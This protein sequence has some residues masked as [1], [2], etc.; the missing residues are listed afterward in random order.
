AL[1][2]VADEA[3]S[4]GELTEKRFNA[5]YWRLHPDI[6]GYRREDRRLQVTWFPGFR[7]TRGVAPQTS[8]K[9]TEAM[10]RGPADHG[11]STRVYRAEDEVAVVEALIAEIRREAAELERAVGSEAKPTAEPASASKPKQQKRSR[12]RPPEQAA[13]ETTM[14]TK[15]A[16]AKTH[17]PPAEP[18]RSKPATVD[19][20]K[21]RALA[22]SMEAKATAELG[23]DRL[24]NTPRRA[25]MAASIRDRARRQLVLAKTLRRIADAGEAGGY[26]YVSR[27][28]NKADL[29]ALETALSGA[30][31]E[32]RKADGVREY[33]KRADPQPVD[34][35]HA[36]HEGLRT[37][38]D[39]LVAVLEFTKG[40]QGLAGPRRVLEKA[41]ERLR[42]WGPLQP[43]EIEAL[44]ELIAVVRKTKAKD[45]PRPIEAMIES[46]RD[47]DRLTQLGVVDT[48]SLRAALREYMT[49]C[50][51][52]QR[53]PKDDPIAVKKRE[54]AFAKIPGF[55]PTPR[56]LVERMVDAAELAPG[57]RV[58]EPSAG[59]GAIALVIRE[60]HPDVEL[61]VIERQVSLRELLELQGF[62]PVADDFCAYT[63]AAPYDRILMNPPFETKQDIQH[64]GHALDLLAPGGRLVAIASAGLS[65]RD[66]PKTKALRDRVEALGGRIESLPQGSFEASGTGVSTVLVVVDQPPAATRREPPRSEPMSDCSVESTSAC[67]PKPKAKAK[68]KAKT[69]AE[70]KTPPG[71]KAKLAAAVAKQNEGATLATKPAPPKKRISKKTSQTAKAPTEAKTSKKAGK[72]KAGKKQTAKL[73]NWRYTTFR[74]DRYRFREVAGTFVVEREKDGKWSAAAATAARA[75]HEKSQSVCALAAQ[76][77]PTCG[78]AK[79]PKA[80]RVKPTDAQKQA[81]RK[82]LGL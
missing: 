48:D 37:E 73:P 22:D 6:H 40:A 28:A 72:K 8:D 26:Q 5:A 38:R 10:V 51:G 1:L 74:N 30:G 31:F 77:L 70:P 79:K 52:D 64:I 27:V 39:G 66:D 81:M 19:A 3:R 29:E 7:R 50:R 54:L 78:D 71:A 34:I 80:S 20:A 17:T 58:L 44:R 65:F 69:S 36:H 56:P 68:T 15:R 9:P 35:D 76:I 46:L 18:P 61:D 49:C 33:W 63:P 32:R 25:N 62:P 43:E 14:T 57:M 41:A 67:R 21:L 82:F 24:E 4:K 11:F 75:I 47:H 13:T 16:R 60:R 53:T 45:M 2:A 42:E 55:F 59:D 23:V 12:Q